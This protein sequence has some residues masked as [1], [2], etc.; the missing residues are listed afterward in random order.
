MKKLSFALTALICIFVFSSFTTQT[1]LPLTF[2]CNTPYISSDGIHIT[3]NGGLE[4]NVTGSIGLSYD[5]QVSI[6]NGSGSYQVS[7]TSPSVTIPPQGWYNGEAIWVYVF[8]TAI[9]DCRDLNGNP[10]NGSA[11]GSI[12]YWP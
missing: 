12:V 6:L 11:T 2:A 7:S 4:I 3:P 9:G 10:Q 1:Y 8:I 5:Y